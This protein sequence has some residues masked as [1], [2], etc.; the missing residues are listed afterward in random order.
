MSSERGCLAISFKDANI[1][2]TEFKVDPRYLNFPSKK[3]VG[4]QWSLLLE[5]TVGNRKSTLGEEVINT[6]IVLSSDLLILTILFP[7]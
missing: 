1:C 6:A 2:N 4:M 5:K 7:R 3:G